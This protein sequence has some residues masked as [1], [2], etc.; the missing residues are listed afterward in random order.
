FDPLVWDRQRFEHLWGWPYRFE[1][2]VPAAKRQFGYYAMPMLWREDI[3]GWVNLSTR[4]GKLV[5]ERGF[6]KAIPQERAF[7]AECAAEVS[8]FEAFLRKRP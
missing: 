8:R 4:E 3:I 2:Y 7:E 6:R 5:V 1:A